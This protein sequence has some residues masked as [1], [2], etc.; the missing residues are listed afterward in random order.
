MRVIYDI[1]IL[2]NGARFNTRTG[3]FRV[4][5]ALA[6]R[7]PE[8][9]D[10]SVQFSSMKNLRETLAYLRS[11]FPAGAQE[12]LKEIPRDYQQRLNGLFDSANANMHA[13]QGAAQ[14]AWR[15]ACRILQTVNTACD[16]WAY[17]VNAQSLAN[18]NVFHS[19][20]YQLPP[21]IKN[22]PHLCRFITV[23]DMIPVLYPQYFNNDPNHIL[24]EILASLGPEDYVIAI[25][26]ATRNDVCEY[27]KIAP[28]RVF[29][30]PLAAD[31]KTFYPCRDAERQKQARDTYNI[32]DAPYLLTL[33]TLEP[34]KNMDHVIRC[35]ARLVQE[36]EL[37]N[38]NLVLAGSK[39]WDFERIFGAMAAKSVEGR[40]I[41]TGRVA[42]EDLAALYSGALA[43]T[44]MSHYEGFGLPPLEAMQ[45]GT[46]VITSN[47]SSL[48]EVVGD[49]GVMLAPDDADGWCQALLDIYRHSDRRE[50]MG[51]KSLLRAGQFSWARCAQ[52]TMN[53][54]RAAI[55]CRKDGLANTCGF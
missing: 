29:V 43:F 1:S 17:A 28:S 45:C 13:T 24:H 33:S 41:W 46:P 25:S 7:L 21:Q 38:T 48:P 23:Y 6:C 35:F 55:A 9:P 3:I 8:T 18:A 40:I 36:G 42:D 15:M 50:E 49:A 30:T 27:L 19:S 31:P 11:E 2:G 32:P 39:G 4:V 22:A 44:Y 5:E 16:T 26:E 47:T 20:F 10:C 14:T 51:R 53:A 54:Y 34:R 12:K 52:T 37:G